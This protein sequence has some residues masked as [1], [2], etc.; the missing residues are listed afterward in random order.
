MSKKKIYTSKERALKRA[1]KENLYNKE[2]GF[3]RA[4]KYDL[5]E[6]KIRP[7]KDVYYQRK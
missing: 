2:R 6:R 4:K 7:K 1:K 5:H 3:T